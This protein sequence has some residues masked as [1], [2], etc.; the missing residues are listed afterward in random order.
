MNHHLTLK[1]QEKLNSHLTKVSHSN[2]HTHT[3]T[4]HMNKRIHRLSFELRNFYH[5]KQQNR[6]FL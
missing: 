3:H 4:N 5:T 1:T 6:K 2:T